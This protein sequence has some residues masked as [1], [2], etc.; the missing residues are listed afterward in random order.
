MQ[1]FIGISF[2]NDIGKRLV[3]QRRER[4]LS[5]SAWGGNI[6]AGLRGVDEAHSQFASGTLLMPE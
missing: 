3:L 6:E 1:F 4:R 5:Q 2:R